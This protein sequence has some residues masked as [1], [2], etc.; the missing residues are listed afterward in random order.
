MG[1]AYRLRTS[2]SSKARRGG[3]GRSTPIASVQI[4]S[5]VHHCAVCCPLTDHRQEK[6]SRTTN[7][8]GVG[9]W[10]SLRLKNPPPA[11][12]CMHMRGGQARE[13]PIGLGIVK[14]A[15]KYAS[16]P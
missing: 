14:R 10:I 9:S 4:L 15:R 3:G 13:E 16:L 1:L 8:R 7:E 12:M 2:I 5:P 11:C 6:G